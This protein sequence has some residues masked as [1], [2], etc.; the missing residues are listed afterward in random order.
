[1]KT[2]RERSYEDV[3][4][5]LSVRRKDLRKSLRTVTVAWMYGVVWMSCVSGSHVN[6][7]ARKLGFDDFAFGLMTAIPF[8]ATFGQLLATVLI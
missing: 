8:V 4:P 2:W 6:T 3:L 5:A 1:M 7:F